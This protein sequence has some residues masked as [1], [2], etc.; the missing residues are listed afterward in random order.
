[1][2]SVMSRSALPPLIAAGD[3]QKCGSPA[4]HRGGGGPVHYIVAALSAVL[5]QLQRG[6]SAA[7]HAEPAPVLAVPAVL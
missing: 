4:A 1:M 3:S 5:L 6:T 7:A 2:H